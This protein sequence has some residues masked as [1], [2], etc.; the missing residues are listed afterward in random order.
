MNSESLIKINRKAVVSRPYFF[1]KI[2]I[3]LKKFSRRL[4]PN[5]LALINWQ[6]HKQRMAISPHETIY[7]NTNQIKNICFNNRHKMR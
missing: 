5:E 7:N 6:T 1:P 2:H 4:A 3:L